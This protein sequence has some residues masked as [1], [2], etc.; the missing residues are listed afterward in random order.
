VDYK[1]QEKLLCMLNESRLL[2][3][4]LDGIITGGVS[5][6]DFSMAVGIDEKTAHKILQNLTQNQIGK[7]ENDVVNFESG[8]KLKVAIFALKN[9]APID[10]VSKQLDWRDFEGLVAQILKSND[11]VVMKNFTMTKPRLE[12]DVIGIKLGI[13]LLIDCKHWKRQ[14]V[15]T[16][17][18]AVKKQISRVQHYVSKTQG[19]V[20]VPA[21][22]T[23]YQ[24]QLTFVDKVPIIPITRFSSFID[25]FYG[26]L[27]K[28]KTIET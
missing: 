4:A 17:T 27:D 1:V 21:I 11:F 13:A 2:V 26:N 9:N 10:D 6:Q 25:E 28:I 24:E 5:V 8:D 15:S 16:L 19:S 14:S 12:I 18:N 7:F 3:N 23:L 20:A 22:V